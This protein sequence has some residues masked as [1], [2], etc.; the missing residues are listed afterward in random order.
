MG[1]DRVGKCFN[2]LQL[3]K[4]SVWMSREGYRLLK[5]PTTA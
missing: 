3:H 2:F 4:H 1:K 5:K